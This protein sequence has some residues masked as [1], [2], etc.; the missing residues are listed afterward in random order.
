MPI[1]KC[2]GCGW[3]G[4]HSGPTCP[5]CSDIMFK[6]QSPDRERDTN[7]RRQSQRGRASRPPEWIQE[8]PKLKMRYTLGGRAERLAIREKHLNRSLEA[9]R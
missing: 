9:F 7:E 5:C 8:E 2:L 4:R 6:Q 3:L 1:W